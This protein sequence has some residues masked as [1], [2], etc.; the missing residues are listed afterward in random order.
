MHRLRKGC[1]TYTWLFSD[2]FSRVVREVNEK[3]AGKEIELR[4]ERAR[5]WEVKQL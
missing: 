5:G 4:D 1:V 3:V 2:P